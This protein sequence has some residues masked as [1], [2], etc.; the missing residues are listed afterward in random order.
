MRSISF[1]YKL[2]SQAIILIVG[3][4]AFISC[5]KDDFDFIDPQPQATSGLLITPQ[6]YDQLAT[7]APSNYYE[8]ETGWEQGQTKPADDALMENDLGTHLDVFI[9]GIDDNYWKEFHLIQG[10]I[11]AGGLKANVT[12]QVADLLTDAWKTMG[13]E[14]NP[15]L[16]LTVGKRYDVYV[17]VNNTMTNAH[18]GS[19]TALLSLVNHNANVYK[20]YGNQG[21]EYD[22]S[23]RMMMDG[24]VVWTLEN[25][26]QLQRIEVPLKRAE[27]KIVAKIQFDP[28]FYAS[29]IDYNYVSSPI[30]NPAWKWTNWCFDSKVFADAPDITPTLQTNTGRNNAILTG[31]LNHQKYYHYEGL[32]AVGQNVEVY[33]TEN[34]KDTEGNRYLDLYPSADE[35]YVDGVPYCYIVTYDYC[36]TWGENA[37]ELAPYMLLSYPFYSKESADATNTI[38]TFNY[39]RIPLCDQT[40]N[41][42]LERN[43]IY[44]V[45]ATISGSGSTS[46]S[47]RVND[48][49]LNYQVVD[50]T[51][52]ENEVVNILAEKFFYFYVTP[53]RYELRGN[54]TQTVDLAYY[55]PE[56]SVVQV[57]N[58]KIYYYNKDAAQVLQYGSNNTQL[59]NVFSS[60]TTPNNI[61]Q[62]TS[63]TV[64]ADGTIRISSEALANK[65]VKYISFTAFTTFVDENNQTQT[66]TENVFIK[67]F[68]TDNIQNVEGWFSYKQD[69]GTTRTIREYSWNPT[70]DGWDS[71][72]GYENNIE[73]TK[74]EH[75]NAVVEYRNST[76]LTDGT[77]ADHDASNYYY[78]Y[79][80]GMDGSYT[81]GNYR[82][83]ISQGVNRY[84]TN[85]EN[86]ASLGYDGYWYWGDTRVEGT[87]N[88]YDWRGNNGTSSTGQRYRWTNYYRTK[89]YKTHYYARLYYR[90]ITINSNWVIWNLDSENRYNTS[91]TLNDNAMYAKVYRN[92]YGIYE[93]D[94]TYSYYYGYLANY[95][96][97]TGYTNNHM[98]IVQISSTSDDYILGRPQIN[99]STH[100]SQDHVVSPAFMI[101]SQLGALTI[102]GTFNASNAATHCS[103]Y[104]EVAQDGTTYTGWRLPTQEEVAIILQYQQNLPETMAN[105]L[106][107]RF[108]YTLDGDAAE[109]PSPTGNNS[110]TRFVRCVRDLSPA[111]V[112]AINSKE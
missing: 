18:I 33:F 44:K 26:D 32:D 23:R 24:H 110:T 45:E 76:R 12:D 98:Y 37:E 13:S 72:D 49:R 36:N 39:Y 75:D 47:G 54:D 87:R 70:A 77:P 1:T 79:S 65:A 17:A 41:T 95:G 6:I 68:P 14:G 21:N 74:E 91:K 20:L 3:A 16:K 40:K 51:H 89:Y 99:A 96:D 108:Y 109:N 112:E 85:G 5:A 11:F 48:V 97:R 69:G 35:R 38:T 67:H 64:N 88:N 94:E 42:G 81:Q 19:K 22:Q 28:A 10:E 2:L 50:W 59:N 9:S 103:Q 7:R 106:T 57:R 61:A 43:H 4:A 53:K 58:V 34:E 90:D 66:L 86:N 30:G 83:N 105:V 93:I 78:D 63:I 101:A 92:G 82:N 31:T 55:A 25:D 84:N 52:N 60:F 102:S 73:C 46:L 29:L 56:G 15:N 8:E 80:T 104:V 111:E 71:Y 107:A 27:A 62:P 100:Q